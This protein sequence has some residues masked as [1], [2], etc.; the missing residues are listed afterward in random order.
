M[1]YANYNIL[2]WLYIKLSV[3]RIGARK[4]LLYTRIII[5]HCNNPKKHRKFG[6]IVLARPRLHNIML[7]QKKNCSL[8]YLAHSTL[9]Q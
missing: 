7:E 4:H 5:G 9:I 3:G 6:I 1:R 8:I 2:H